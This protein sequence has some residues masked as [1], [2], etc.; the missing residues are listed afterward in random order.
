MKK[1]PYTCLMGYAVYYVLDLKSGSVHIGTS[2]T[3]LSET[4]KLWGFL[5]LCQLMNQE[6]KPHKCRRHF[7]YHVP[8]RKEN[9]VSRFHF[10]PLQAKVVWAGSVP[11]GSLCEPYFSKRVYIRYLLWNIFVQRCEIFVTILLYDYFL[12][13]F[14]ICLYRVFWTCVSCDAFGRTIGAIYIGCK[15]Y[16]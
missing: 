2:V 5:Y 8:Y 6:T 12:F 3:A 11:L 14:V 10:R 13:T 15:W 9:I 4:E 7:C 16:M 1:K